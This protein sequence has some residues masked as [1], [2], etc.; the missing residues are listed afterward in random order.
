MWI[1]GFGKTGWALYRWLEGNISGKGTRL[2]RRLVDWEKFI[3]SVY[4]CS[5]PSTSHPLCGI[6]LFGLGLAGV[7]VSVAPKKDLLYP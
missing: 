1:K 7:L 4:K 3:K 6:A 2:E 5:Q